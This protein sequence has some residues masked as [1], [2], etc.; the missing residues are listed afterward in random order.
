MTLPE[1]VPATDALAAA[2]LRA[3]H[4]RPW[5]APALFALVPIDA[6]GS[7]SL[8]VDQWWRLYVDA[9]VVLRWTV[10]D[11]AGVL[12]HEVEHLL[13]DHHLRATSAGV[14]PEERLLWNLATDAAINDD[15]IADGVSLP[16]PILP[17][18]LSLRD[19]DMEE[20]YFAVLRAR[21]QS[22][23][24]LGI[25]RD[26]GSGA[27]GI[28]RSYDLPP[29]GAPIVNSTV[30]ERIRDRVQ[31]ALREALFGCSD[32]PLSDRRSAIERGWPVVDW[33]RQ[34]AVAVRTAVQTSAG[35]GAT[36]WN[37]EGRRQL[38]PILTA[39]HRR[40][41]P[42][43]AV[44]VDTSGSV[45][46]AQL[47]RV[48]AEVSSLCRLAGDRR[49]VVVAGDV[50]FS[51]PQVVRS[52]AEVVLAGGGGTDLRVGL[53]Q[54]ASLRPRPDVIVVLTDGLTPWPGA[55]PRRPLHVI[56]V[57]GPEKV[58]VPGAR[59]VSIPDVA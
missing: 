24:R 22:S 2:R 40:S 4:W 44:L 49:V 17:S 50:Q 38:E 21:S 51:L 13:R 7:G 52:G 55:L 5:F 39:G 28:R 18:T 25:E 23:P 46:A 58:R 14:S 27:D 31:T 1:S 26:C 41:R 3:A 8:A 35:I 15:L 59:T 12:L 16:A 29:A 34:L 47:G 57:L 37:R 20:T 10:E 19:G 45:S 48:L 6:P 9:E 11:L 53:R 32:T 36:T 42:R 56:G 54:M 33:R 30:A 43:V